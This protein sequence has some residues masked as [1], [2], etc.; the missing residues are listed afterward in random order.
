MN[1]IRRILL[2]ATLALM[3]TAFTSPIAHAQEFGQDR[4]FVGTWYFFITIAGAPPCQCIQIAT[5]HADGTMEGPASDKQSGDQRGVWARQSD[6]RYT[7][8]VLQNAINADGTP[9]G[10]FIIKATVDLAGTDAATGKATFQILS[11]GG[12]PVFSGTSTFT[13]TRI[14]P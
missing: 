14:R 1:L 4:S 2:T 13:A 10:L 8:T 7:F 5:I 12:T 6:G 9:G 3:A 11:N